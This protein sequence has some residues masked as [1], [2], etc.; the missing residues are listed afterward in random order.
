MEMPA[1]AMDVLVDDSDEDVTLP[2]PWERRCGLEGQAVYYNTLT[3]ES[4]RHFPGTDPPAVA[5][6]PK[7][8]N[9]RIN[10]HIISQCVGTHER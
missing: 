9:H 8:G 7:V 1:A 3:H 4:Q 10:P 6:V 2:L 5:A